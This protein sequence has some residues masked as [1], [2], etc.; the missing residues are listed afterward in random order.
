MHDTI[1][2]IIIDD[3]PVARSII[4]NYCSY[5]PFVQIIGEFGNALEAKIFL[6]THKTHLVFLDINMPVLNGIGFIKTLNNVPLIVFTTAYEE[7]AVNAFDLSAVDYLLKPFSLDRF[8]V[9]IDKV[10]EKLGLITIPVK[11]E[12]VKD[13]SFFIRSEGNIY[14]LAYNDCLYAEAQGNYTRVVTAA[15]KYLTKTPF[16]VFIE[17]LPPYIFLRVHRSFVINRNK[18]S[19]FSGGRVFVD[20]YEI[21]IAT[22]YRQAFLRSIGME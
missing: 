18:I 9:A 2:C 8:I 20:Q 7:Y 6:A 17:E 14:R 13:T 3:E 12:P 4:R 22:S 5:L 16:S 1:T 10:K 19:H 11:D 15:A 21:P